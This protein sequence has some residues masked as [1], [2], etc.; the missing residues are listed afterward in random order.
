VFW[1][2]AFAMRDPGIG[3]ID[4]AVIREIKE[5]IDTGGQGPIYPPFDRRS[6]AP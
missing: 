6:G 4:S 2:G 3:P 1:C 5:N